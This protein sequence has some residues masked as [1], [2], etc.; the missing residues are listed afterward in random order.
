MNKET[1]KQMIQSKEAK[2]FLSFIKSGSFIL[3]CIL[4][5][6]YFIIQGPVYDNNMNK[7]YEAI[8]N[9]LASLRNVTIDEKVEIINRHLQDVPNY[10]FLAGILFLCGI[11]SVCYAAYRA[12]NLEDNNSIQDQEKTVQDLEDFISGK[13]N[14]SPNS[15]K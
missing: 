10:D 12:I 7:A 11:G 5:T 8:D 3:G 6:L 13:R 2:A 9:E 1:F 4:L 14:D 15:K